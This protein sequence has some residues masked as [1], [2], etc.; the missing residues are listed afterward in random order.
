MFFDAFYIRII[1]YGITQVS[2]GYYIEMNNK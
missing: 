1:V 2:N